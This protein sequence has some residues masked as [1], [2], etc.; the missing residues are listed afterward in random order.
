MVGSGWGSSGEAARMR[1]VTVARF[2]PTLPSRYG[3]VRAAV[4]TA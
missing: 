4:E 1:I 2:E 3:S